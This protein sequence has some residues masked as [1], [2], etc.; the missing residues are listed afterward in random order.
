MFAPCMQSIH[1]QVL[2]MFI[3]RNTTWFEE[4]WCAVVHHWRVM[5]RTPPP[6]PP[7]PR[8]HRQSLC[9]AATHEISKWMEDKCAFMSLRADSSF[10]FL[11]HCQKKVFSSNEVPSSISTSKLSAPT[12]QQSS[13]SSVD[14]LAWMASLWFELADAISDCCSS[15][16]VFTK[17]AVWSNAT[18]LYPQ[19]ACRN[20]TCARRIALWH[21]NRAV[22]A[23]QWTQGNS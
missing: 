22:V 12:N 10:F 4:L 3:W 18:A 1:L 7:H 11:L 19:R 13:A 5:D 14:I 20:K 21:V 2:K 6:L 15:V 16:V 9:L 23:E 17:R 8:F